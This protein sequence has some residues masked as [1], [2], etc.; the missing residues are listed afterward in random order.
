LRD[1]QAVATW[2][3]SSHILYRSLRSAGGTELMQSFATKAISARKVPWSHNVRD[4]L[5]FR[6]RDIRA[7]LLVPKRV[8][9]QPAHS[10]NRAQPARGSAALH[11]VVRYRYVG[12]PA[13]TESLNSVA[14]ASGVL[15]APSPPPQFVHVCTTT[16]L[17]CL[18]SCPSALPNTIS[19]KQVS[20]W[21]RVAW[22][23]VETPAV[24]AAFAHSA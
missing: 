19:Q 24:S 3:A 23:A 6:A 4:T 13:P 2:R 8:P 10:K 1:R 22:M 9:A 16:N 20:G 14:H 7:V 11:L 15:E 5:H 21:Q 17:C 18:V 12:P